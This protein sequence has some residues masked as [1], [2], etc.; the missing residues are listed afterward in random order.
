MDQDG[1]D[2][3]LQYLEE[4]Y[5]QYMTQND[6]TATRNSTYVES[7]NLDEIEAQVSGLMRDIN[8]TDGFCSVCHSM[9]DNWPDIWTAAERLQRELGTSVA[10]SE[11]LQS[12]HPSS[13]RDNHEFWMRGHGIAYQ[14]PCQGQTVR[15]DAATRK[16]CR[17]CG[18]ILQTLKDQDWLS[19]YRMIEKRFDRLGK[20]SRVSL[21]FYMF[22]SD[23]ETLELGFPGRLFKP[24]YSFI[25]INLRLYRRVN[26]RK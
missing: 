17:C 15:L 14:M 11:R 12:Q 21:V 25:P 8:V 26:H 1:I 20:L 10:G 16:G 9:L 24:F 23:Q 22:E 6:P 18:L 19:L 3:D 5:A 7:L 13:N 4:W 2:Q